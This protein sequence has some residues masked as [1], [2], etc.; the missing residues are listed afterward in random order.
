MRLDTKPGIV[1][2]ILIATGLALLAIRWASRTALFRRRED[3]GLADLY[4]T[5]VFSVPVDVQTFVELIS[6]IGECYH[7]APGKLRGEDR[8]DGILS[9]FDSWDL[10][11][12]EEDLADRL[13]REY[14]IRLPQD[15]QLQTV[16]ELIEYG[17]SARQN[18]Q[19]GL[20]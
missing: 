12:G 18:S 20:A 13:T 2:L 1:L 4:R 11:G 15:R 16:Q 3:K 14:A 8:F 19:P 10:G 17:Q 7:V 6:L 9:Q 5:F